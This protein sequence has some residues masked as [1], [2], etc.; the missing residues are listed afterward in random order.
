MNRAAKGDKHGRN[1]SSDLKAVAATT[2]VWLGLALV[3]MLQ[4]T[5]T[6]TQSTPK[7]CN[8]DTGKLQA[9]FLLYLGSG[10]GVLEQPF[11]LAL[12]RGKGGSLLVQRLDYGLEGVQEFHTWDAVLHP[13]QNIAGAP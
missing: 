6:D 13:L 4:V 7:G 2:V 10:Y 8:C 9:I 1:G 11:G 5:N 3:V 12:L